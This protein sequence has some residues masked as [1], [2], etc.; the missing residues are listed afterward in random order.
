MILICLSILAVVLAST[1]AGYFGMWSCF[2]VWFYR[3]EYFI[4]TTPIASTPQLHTLFLCSCCC[5]V[6]SI[7]NQPCSTTTCQPLCVVYLTLRLLQTNPPNR[8][9]AFSNSQP[10]KFS[11]KETHIMSVIFLWKSTL[12]ST[13]F[14]TAF[15]K[16]WGYFDYTIFFILYQCQFSDISIDLYT[17]E[18]F[19]PTREIC[20][21]STICKNFN[22][23]STQ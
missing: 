1:L 17:F 19:T 21:C 8:P 7:D 9:N 13:V 4:S 6:L 3:D 16:S 12:Q 22:M 14:F 20:I 10:N 15:W 23:H 5:Y 2:K 18:V 11:S